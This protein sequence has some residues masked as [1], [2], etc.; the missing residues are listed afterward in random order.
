MPA[1]VAVLSTG[2]EL[3]KVDEKPGPFQIRNSNTP[4]LMAVLGRLGCSTTDLGVARDDPQALCH[5]LAPDSNLM[6]F[7]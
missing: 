2:N 3:V 7:S 1:R 4:M 6:H 5:A